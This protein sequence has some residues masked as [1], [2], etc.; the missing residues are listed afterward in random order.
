MVHLNPVCPFASRDCPN[1][2]TIDNKL[3]KRELFEKWMKDYSVQEEQQFV[4]E[5]FSNNYTVFLL[6]DLSS[7]NFSPF[8]LFVLL[9]YFQPPRIRKRN[10]LIFNDDEDTSMSPIRSSPKRTKST[11]TNSVSLPR[12][13][14]SMYLLYDKRHNVQRF[15]LNFYCLKILIV[16]AV[17]FEI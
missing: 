8:N 11:P 13:K 1:N 12:F 17:V 4:V 16:G 2:L 5:Y 15:T 3:S 9:V 7:L 10:R 6:R 14:G